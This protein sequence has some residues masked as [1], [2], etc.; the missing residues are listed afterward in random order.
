MKPSTL[1]IIDAFG[2]EIGII[3]QEIRKNKAMIREVDKHYKPYYYQVAFIHDKFSRIF[4]NMAI[5]HLKPKTPYNR[6]KRLQTMLFLLQKPS[7]KDN[8]G[9]E[10][11]K[12]MAISIERAR[13]ANMLDLYSWERLKKNYSRYVACCP[14]HGEKTPSFTIY[15][16]NN[17][18]YCF[19]CGEGGGPIDFIMKLKD[20]SFKDAVEILS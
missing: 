18:W 10:A 6:L 15:T 13:N 8:K 7:K 4:W 9:L 12:A 20:C 5:D 17:S 11:Y 1:D 14:L 16:T 3:K 19:G 2:E